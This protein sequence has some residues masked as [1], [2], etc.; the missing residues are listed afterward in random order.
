MVAGDHRARIHP[1]PRYALLNDAVRLAHFFNAH[2]IAVVAVTGF[3][4]RDVEVHLVVHVVRLLLAQVPREAGA[5]EHRASKAEC[6][7][8]LWRYDA[9]THCA[10]LPDSVVGE[11]C[12]V[13]INITR[14]FVAEVFNEI[15]Q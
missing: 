14:E 9:N 11:Q 2:Q 7:G 3:A 8:A 12:F 4:N 10:L 1:Q 6:Q 13:L 15:K 5:P